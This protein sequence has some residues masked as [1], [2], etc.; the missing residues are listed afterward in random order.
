MKQSQTAL[1]PEVLEFATVAV[2]FCSLLHEAAQMA[3]AELTDKLLRI[4]PLL[5]IKTLPLLPS[6]GDD[7][8]PFEQEEEYF[9]PEYVSEREYT[10]VER[11]L[12][13]Q[14]GRGDLFLE[15]L[16]PEMQYSDRPLTARLSE[17]LTDIYQPVGNFVGL[18]RDEVF[19]LIPL[20]LHDLSEQF[21]AYWGDR[22][23]AA[24]RALHHLKFTESLEP[25]E[26]ASPE[27]EREDF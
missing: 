2:P 19:D 5:Y 3:P 1:T 26:E 25:N 15:A 12:E 23:L 21:G 17:T 20:A 18:L 4:L 22:I 6:G 7:A 11:G 16:S 14:F 13:Q 9:L 8:V 24:L 27:E 10:L